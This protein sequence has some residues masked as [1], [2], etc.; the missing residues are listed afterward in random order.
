MNFGIRNTSFVYPNGTG[1]LWE[2]T[3]T[4]LQCVTSPIKLKGRLDKVTSRLKYLQR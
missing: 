1:N 4:Q 3:K 2:D